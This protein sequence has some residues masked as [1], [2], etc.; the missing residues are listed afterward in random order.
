[1]ISELST[2]ERDRE[3]LPGA[4]VLCRVLIREVRAS[5]HTGETGMVK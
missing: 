3:A 5:H 2:A 1:M 4:Q